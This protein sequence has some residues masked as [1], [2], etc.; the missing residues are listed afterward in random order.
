MNA[1]LCLLLFLS[2]R[3]CSLFWKGTVEQYSVMLQQAYPRIKAA[4][5]NCTGRASPIA[6][7]H[8]ISSSLPCVVVFGAPAFNDD[9]WIDHVYSFGARD[10]FDVMATHPR[11][12]WFL[13]SVAHL[14]FVCR[15]RYQGY[16]AYPP[17]HPDDGNRWWLLHFPAVRK[18]R[19][20]D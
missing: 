15:A 3:N 11:V 4:D 1:L 2:F 10:S 5:P 6:C 20:Q 7:C 9:P 18:V 12:H 8:L 16:S 19:T 17:D 13:V 14:L